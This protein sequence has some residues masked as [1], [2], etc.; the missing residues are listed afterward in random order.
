MR[1]QDEEYRGAHRT[2][3][4]PQSPQEHQQKSV[5]PVASSSER[6]LFSPTS[7]LPLG[8]GGRPCGVDRACGCPA[9]LYLAVWLRVSCFPSLDFSLLICKMRERKKVKK[10]KSLSCVQ[11]FATP[12]T[13]AHQVLCPWDFPGKSTGVDCHFL[14]QEIFPT[15]GSNPGLPHCRQTLYCLSHQEK[16]NISNP[17]PLPTYR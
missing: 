12:W 9:L 6:P 13:V 3:A 7:P 5:R 4:A 16:G 15:Q 2:P 17:F 11:L 8:G 1:V 10:V 14:L